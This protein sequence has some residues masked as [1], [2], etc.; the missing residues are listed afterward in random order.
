M[1]VAPWLLSASLGAT[2]CTPQQTR[3]P[4]APESSPTNEETHDEP[5]LE[6]CGPTGEQLHGLDWVPADASLTA[7]VDL[8]AADL[9][10]ALVHL[11]EAARADDHDLPMDVA[12]GF[13]HWDFQVPLIR[14]TLLQAGFEPAELLA[15]RVG[16]VGTSWVFGS[17][18]DIDL[19]LERLRSIWGLEVR[20]TA[21]GALA[22]PGTEPFAFD[23]VFLPGDRVALT[24][25]G[26]GSDFT[27]AVMVPTTSE[28][29]RPSNLLEAL[30]PAPIRAIVQGPALA[31][32]GRDE[33]PM[34]RSLRASGES[35]EIDGRL[36]PTS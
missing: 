25:A 6:A 1:R 29:P 12:F 10:A 24:P 21:T 2:A 23:V 15:L 14:A 8:T 26:R 34:T 20:R 31:Y 5:V 16:D 35:L 28:G 30:D 27:R 19:A 9:E 32:P 4:T 33:P 22:S 3:A 17:T 36:A 11:A 18:C 7:V 13:A